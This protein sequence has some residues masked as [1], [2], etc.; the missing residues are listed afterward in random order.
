MKRFIFAAAALAC[1][2][3]FASEI[4][5]D[6][7]LDELDYVSGERVR[8]VVDVKNMSPDKIGVG[9]K[10]AKDVLSI[11]VF[12]ATDM[13]RL[14]TVSDIPFVSAF[15]LASN[16]GTKLEV[17][18]DAH[19][20]LSDQHKYLARPVFVHGGIR[21]EGRLRA[22]DIVRG[23]KVTSAVQMFSNRK[24]LRREFE[25]VKWSRRNHEHLFA[26]AKDTDD[27]GGERK[28]RTFDLG[29]MMR[30]TPPV[31]SIMPGGEVVILH[32]ADRDN[33]IRSEFW[34]MPDGLEFVGAMAVRDPETAGQD[35]VQELYESSGGIKPVDRPWWKIW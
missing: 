19:F 26:T 22:F 24:G 27:A 32:R 4:S 35:R 2:A 23:M 3:L 29:D 31:V 25:L 10:G 12:L 11:E 16:Q 20:P 34:S 14:E 9:Y 1:H 15:E 5:I 18:L 13:T 21:Y 6:L 17:L 30:M 7:K 33:F 8:G 28:W